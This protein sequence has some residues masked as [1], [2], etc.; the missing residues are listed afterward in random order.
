MVGE[1]VVCV[2]VMGEVGC[3]ERVKHTFQCAAHGLFGAPEHSVVDYLW[4]C[5]CVGRY[6]R[7][8]QYNRNEK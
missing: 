3:H 8:R 2:H 7:I 1:E 5:F 6:Y 4:M